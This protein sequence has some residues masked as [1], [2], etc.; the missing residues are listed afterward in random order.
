MNRVEGGKRSG[1]GTHP[2]RTQLQ[3]TTAV[4]RVVLLLTSVVVVVV[5]VLTVEWPKGVPKP[6]QE[7]TLS[8]PKKI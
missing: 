2:Q 3:P 4:A 5:V 6:K 1:E 8:P 7:R